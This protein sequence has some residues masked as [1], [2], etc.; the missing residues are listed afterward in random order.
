[1]D[2][3]SWIIVI[4]LIIMILNIKMYIDNKQLLK[5]IE[6]NTYSIVKTINP[7]YNQRYYID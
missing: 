6:N 5:A 4:V 1:M 3:Q 7:T 2:K